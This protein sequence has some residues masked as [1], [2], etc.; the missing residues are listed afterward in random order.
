MVARLHHPRGG[1]GG[2]GADRHLRRFMHSLHGWE[3]HVLVRLR[4]WELRQPGAGAHRQRLLRAAGHA[5]YLHHCAGPALHGLEKRRCKG[6]GTSHH[7][8][9]AAALSPQKENAD[10][11]L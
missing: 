6:W 7:H 8:H 11:C 2:S 9:H 3:G 4:E 1:P 10:T 5:R